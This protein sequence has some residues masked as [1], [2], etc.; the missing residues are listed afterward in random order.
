MLGITGDF[1]HNVVL[2]VRYIHDVHIKVFS[3]IIY[4]HQ[5]ELHHDEI[6]CNLK[7][8]FIKE[9]KKEKVLW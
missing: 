8:I 9:N 6:T 2:L 3:F 7:S 5:K 1:H 4:I